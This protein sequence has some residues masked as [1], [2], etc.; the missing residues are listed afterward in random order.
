MK[1]Y[2]YKF[3][4]AFTL[5]LLSYILKAVIIFTPL[6]QNV[7]V[8]SGEEITVNVL[9]QNVGGLRT[10]L[11]V[12]TDDIP[13]GGYLS[14]GP[15]GHQYLNGGES[16]N[17][18]FKFKKNVTSNNT[19]SYKFKYSWQE[20]GT[21]VTNQ[22]TITINVTYVALGCN[23]P[24]PNNLSTTNITSTSAK[25]N[26]NHVGGN[27][28][29]LIRLSSPTEGMQL[30]QVGGPSRTIT[31]LA[32]NTM[33]QWKIATKCENG[34]YGEYGSTMTFYTLSGC[35]ENV[36]INWPIT[37]SNNYQVSNIL[38]SNSVINQ[39]LNV[40]FRASEIVLK[41]GFNVKGESTGVFR[42]YVDPCVP[43]LNKMESEELSSEFI[44]K[45]DVG[46][47]PI[48]SPNPTTTILNIDKIADIYEW[49]LVDIN[50]KTVESGKVNNSIQTKITI[51][52]SRL[53][54]G[55]YYFNAIM[56]NGELF[57][58]TVMKK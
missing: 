26:W 47:Q 1:N 27:A 9:A 14:H 22:G 40:V 29:Y 7:S 10:L 16:M 3:F 49:K 12:I 55:V 34:D 43:S 36:N 23:L 20:Q 4:F 42:A 51:N 17:F 24:S 57:Q 21:T 30:Y 8:T 13:D 33:Y 50:G 56:K 25:L 53:M 46:L 39:N 58:K 15:F 54:P 31:N 48:L 5:C 19:T 6:T 11:G 18:N 32:P 41:P 2:I 37:T 52:T 28:G 35:R 45:K 38:T 44:I